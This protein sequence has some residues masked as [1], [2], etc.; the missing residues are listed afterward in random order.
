MTFNMESLNPCPC[1]G[2]WPI[3]HREKVNDIF[4]S[5]KDGFLERADIYLVDIRCKNC[6]RKTSGKHTKENIPD[7]VLQALGME[8]N[9]VKE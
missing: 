1:C 9:E 4:L 5:D 8:W 6:N 2:E 7:S 3:I